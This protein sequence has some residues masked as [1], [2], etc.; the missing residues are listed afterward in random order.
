MKK[1]FRIIAITSI[2]AMAVGLVGCRQKRIS[3]VDMVKREKTE[4]QAY[5]D[6]ARLT[7]AKEFPADLVTPENVYVQVP[8]LEN[9]YI[10]VVKKGDKSL[11]EDGKTIVVTRFNMESMSP[12]QKMTWNIADGA[13]GGSQPLPFIYVAEYNK[14]YPNLHM[15]PNATIEAEN[16]PF[17]CRALLEA[18]NIA[19][20]NSEVEIITSFRYGPSFASEAGLPV[21]FTKVTFMPK[22]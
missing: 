9:L 20:M 6:S 10:R 5:M 17:L 16:K 2:A 8:D 12:R 18:V 15:D 19:G 14:N 11:L 13:S 3:Y 21:R 4:M 1:Y 7:V 22:Q